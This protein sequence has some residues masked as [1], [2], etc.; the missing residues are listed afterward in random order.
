[1]KHIQ[2]SFE[3]TAVEKWERDHRIKRTI[4]GD[5]EY[6]TCQNFDDFRLQCEAEEAFAFKQLVAEQQAAS[7]G[8]E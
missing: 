7:C 2:E 8:V 6:V 3:N 4:I 1:M 5:C